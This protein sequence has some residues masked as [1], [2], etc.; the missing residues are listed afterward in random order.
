MITMSDLWA[1][2][3]REQTFVSSVF[4]V[5]GFNTSLIRID[6]MHVADL[7]IGPTLLGEVLADLFIFIGGKLKKGLKASG[8]I[9]RMLKAA[10]ES[11]GGRC[12]LSKLT[13]KMF[14]KNAPARSCLRVK[15]A[16]CRYMLEIVNVLLDVFMQEQT[17]YQLLRFHYV[18]L[19]GIA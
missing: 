13:V 1:D 4:K 10:A 18:L 6:W 5:P 19:S 12:P 16:E 17:P 2:A 9:L 3:V 7:G 11:I 14:L 8:K 15:A